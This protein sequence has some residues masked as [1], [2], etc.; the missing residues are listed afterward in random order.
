[1]RCSI[2]RQICILATSVF[3]VLIGLLV[4]LTHSKLFDYIIKANLKL[5]PNNNLFNIWRK[6]PIPLKIDFYFHNWTNPEDIYNKTI[7]PRF[8]QI[9]PYR[10]TETK[11]KVN[12]TWN[13][14]NTVT[15]KHL[16]RWYFDDVFTPGSLKD[17]VVT[18][19][20]ILL[21]ECSLLIT[22]HLS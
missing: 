9:G 16:R 18:I 14:N 2:I 13:P 5:K 15:Y 21:V 10:F 20:P 8:E 6:N 11:E 7:K 22:I 3:F 12:I 19:N 4:L 17:K 1:M